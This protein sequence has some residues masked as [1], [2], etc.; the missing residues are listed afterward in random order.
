MLCLFDVAGSAHI[1]EAIIRP[2]NGFLYISR[3]L[4]H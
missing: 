3:N 1:H 4:C 2:M